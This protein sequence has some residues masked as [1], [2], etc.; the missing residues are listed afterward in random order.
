MSLRTCSPPSSSTAVTYP[1]H[2][3]A[4]GRS[5]GQRAVTIAATMTARIEW[6]LG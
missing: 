6:P 5:R 4:N 1:T 2:T 3:I